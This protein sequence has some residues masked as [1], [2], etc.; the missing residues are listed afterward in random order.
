[1]AES[2]LAAETPALARKS[3]QPGRAR[4]L[5]LA[6]KSHVSVA[7][8][9]WR[10]LWRNKRRTWLMISGIVFAGF[11][12]I[13]INSLQRGAFDM[14]I[15]ITARFFSGHVQIQHP[16][17]LDEPRMDRTVR[18]AAARVAD[19]QLREEF[20]A[21]APRA[22][23]FALVA[24]SNTSSDTDPPATGALVI[25]VDPV[26][27][28][29][30]IRHS[31]D[32]GRFLAEAGDAYVGSLLAQNLRAGV[33]DELA[34]LGNAE[35]GSVAAM[36]VTVA[37]TFDTGQ[38]AVDR[39]QMLVQLDEF[40]EAFGLPDQVHSIALTL[41][42]PS[43]AEAHAAT[44]TDAESVGVPWQKLL[45]DIE[46][47]AR[48]KYQSS[49]MIY[50]L[51]LVLVIFGVV[52]AFIMTTFE[53]TPEFGMLKAVGMRPGAIIRMMSL[54]ALWMAAIGILVTLAITGTLTG[55]LSVTGFSFGEAY[56]EMVG[57]SF[58]MPDRL[59]PTFGYR[60]ALEFSVAMLIA[61]QVAALIPTVRLRRLNV[62]DALRSAE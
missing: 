3:P 23:A 20:T 56:T 7:A 50:A 46:Q 44:L 58:M 42:G 41:A 28:F 30:A 4:G 22:Q 6:K 24:A 59:Y 5:P 48:L 1:M 33:G 32:A 37:D 17:F 36:V 29:A 10:N 26:L 51:L 19:L 21:V 60:A 31:V 40:Q 43:A 14:M 11:L 35:D 34:I 38:A 55:I 9:A 54:E 62:V 12:V 57:D 8:I 49:Y 39:S 2:V 16:A 47:M 52:N 15:D 25:G 18:N 61:I 53:R 45:P 13:F 27:E